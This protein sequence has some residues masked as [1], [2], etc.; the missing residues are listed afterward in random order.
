MAS[1]QLTFL[2]GAGASIPS[3]MPG[4]AAITD[5]VLTG[6][7]VWRH[8]D[9]RFYVGNA[10]R[11]IQYP[12]DPRLAR[13]LAEEL[14]TIAEGFFARVGIARPVTYEDIQYQARQIADS[15]MGEYENPALTAQIEGLAGKFTAGDWE[16]LRQRADMTADY[17]TDIVRALL[18]GLGHDPSCLDM[19]VQACADSSI[20]PVELV[21]LNHDTLLE[22]ALGHAGVTYG[23]GFERPFGDVMVW[24][25]SYPAGQ[26][27]L[28]KLHG[29][30]DW[31]RLAIDLG[32]GVHQTDVRV[33][34]PDI[35]HLED[36]NGERIGFPLNDGRPLILV[37]TFNKLYDYSGGVYGDQHARFRTRLRETGRLVVA[38]Y[39][40]A[41]KGINRAVIEWLVAPGDRRMVVVHPDP[42]ALVF[43][44][45][46]AIG[47]KWERLEKAGRL[48]TIAAGIEEVDWPLVTS[49]L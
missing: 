45:R 29:S 17:I 49:Y 4:T 13:E 26:P 6:Q 41:D 24:T 32:A 40:F 7:D 34:Q 14:A 15:L 42:E 5:R 10:P 43:G 23:D 19:V 35:D 37:G 33:T 46:Y 36:P 20:P 18:G 31:V 16:L 1:P 44:S 48:A 39:G 9:Q 27:R 3:G 8:T 21:T 38:G 25:D 11:F 28:L 12:D 47:G 22:Q 30:L 2:L